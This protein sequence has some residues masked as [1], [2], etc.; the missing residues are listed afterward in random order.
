M[1]SVSHISRRQQL[2][3]LSWGLL[4][5]GLFA[6]AV[7]AMMVGLASGMRSG[8]GLWHGM[9]AWGMDLFLLALFPVLHSALLL[10][11]G[12]RGLRQTLGAAPALDVT[13]FATVSSALLALVFLGWSPLPGPVLILEGWAATLAWGAFVVGWVLLG[14]SMFEAGLSLQTGAL[15]WLSQFRGKPPSYPPTPTR[16]LHA[17]LNHPIYLSFTLILWSGAHWTLDKLLLALLWTVYCVVGSTWKERRHAART[18]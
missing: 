13:L 6:L 17:W 9:A 12:R 18:K 3:A 7:T 2:S 11:R 8:F 4:C 10:Q 15:G 16:G 14:V 5:H 1:P